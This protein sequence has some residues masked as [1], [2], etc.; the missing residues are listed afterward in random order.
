MGNY[1]GSGNVGGGWGPPALNQ[2]LLLADRE[3]AAKGLSMLGGL[4]GGAIG[5][6]IAAAKPDKAAMQRYYEAT[7][8]EMPNRPKASLGQ[9]AKGALLG[10][11]EEVSP[12]FKARSR[13]FKGLQE[14]ADATYG[15]PKGATMAMS[16]EELQGQVRGLEYQTVQSERQQ[17]MALKQ[18]ELQQQA[19]RNAAINAYYQQQGQAR[20]AAVD[21]DRERFT[22]ERNWQEAH[23]M[24][25]DAYNDPMAAVGYANR[26]APG[27]MPSQVAGDLLQRPGAEAKPA[28]NPSVMEVAP[29]VR[30]L[31]TSPNSAVEVK[32][33][34]QPTATGMR[35]RKVVTRLLEDGSTERTEVPM[36]DEEVTA[37]RGAPAPITGPGDKAK[38]NALRRE[39]ADAIAR[40]ADK[41][42][43][44][45]RFKELTGQDY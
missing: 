37:F 31:L 42:T 33:P 26:I 5:G 32:P 35:P 23:G 15:I 44:R 45:Q 38:L 40:G 36:T 29:G 1:F 25:L 34:A 16:L 7:S 43:V 10:A 13:A 20:Q 17:S 6:G 39:A 27:G 9:I 24:N 30:A 8:A 18:Q 21:L 41:A 3:N 22:A 28:W 4:V 19:E 14:Y 2:G 12:E 11:A